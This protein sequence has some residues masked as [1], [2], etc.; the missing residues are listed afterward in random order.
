VVAVLRRRV[1]HARVR[2]IELKTA[3][4]SAQLLGLGEVVRIE[5]VNEVVNNV[6]NKVMNEM[7]GVLRAS[8]IHIT[9][10]S[11]LHA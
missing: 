4:G 10:A 9:Y 6:V 5:V 7:G 8:K 1:D 11:H 3:G 2:R